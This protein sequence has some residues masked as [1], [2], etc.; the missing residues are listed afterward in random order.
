MLVIELIKVRLRQLVPPT[1]PAVIR[2][3][4]DFCHLRHY[5]I[6]LFPLE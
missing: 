3:W 2:L 5:Y 6:L 1:I 4:V